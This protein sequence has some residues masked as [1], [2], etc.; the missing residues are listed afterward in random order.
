MASL[1]TPLSTAVDMRSGLSVMPCHSDR[2][3]QHGDGGIESEDGH[4][5]SWPQETRRMVDRDR[6]F[7]GGP[8]HVLT[9]T[10]R[11]E[12][13]ECYPSH[14]HEHQSGRRRCGVSDDSAETDSDNG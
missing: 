2:C 11:E 14:E 9:E 3:C 4:G 8:R 12:L 5:S 13:S 1:S 10:D 6:G 7:E